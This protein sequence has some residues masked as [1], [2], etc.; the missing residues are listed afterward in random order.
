MNRP[1]PCCSSSCPGSTGVLGSGLV[2]RAG[3][4]AF[5]YGVALGA[6]PIFKHRRRVARGNTVKF[7][8]HTLQLLPTQQRRSYAGAVVVL[9]EGLD[10][11]L[12]LQHEGR[13]IPSQDAPLSP[14]ALRTGK[15][16]STSVTVPS[17]GP[18][19]LAGSPATVPEPLKAKIDEA[20][21]YDPD[22]DEENVAV[23][24]VSASVRKPTFLQQ[25]R[26]K[27]VQHAKLKGMSIRGMA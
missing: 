25:E 15:G 3:I 17:L 20:K 2:P 9:L 18:K 14:G 23:M 11:R 12:S 22:I 19:S 6:Y 1:R 16:P 24:T 27:A 21:E 10:G 5:G 26:W 8:R 13:K 7:Y 4:P